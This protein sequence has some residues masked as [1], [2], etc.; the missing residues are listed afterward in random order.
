MHHGSS[1]P[2]SPPKSPLKSPSPNL[3]S[4][5]FWLPI[6]LPSSQLVIN[7]IQ[8]KQVCKGKNVSKWWRRNRASKAKW[9]FEEQGK[10]KAWRHSHINTF[11]PSKSLKD[12]D[13]RIRHLLYHW[14]LFLWTVRK[15]SSVSIMESCAPTKQ[16]IHFCGYWEP[17][18]C[19]ASVSTQVIKK[20]RAK[21]MP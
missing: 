10:G 20:S 7:K 6:P 9:L 18:T 16:W 17:F 1:E 8:K 14:V 19:S 4:H 11:A 2:T 15:H 3:I 12:L 5:I 13:R 21:F